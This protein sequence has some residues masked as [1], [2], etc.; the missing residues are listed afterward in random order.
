MTG[1]PFS[2]HLATI[3]LVAASAAL[4]AAGFGF[5][6]SDAAVETIAVEAREPPVPIIPDTLPPTLA[7]DQAFRRPLFQ[8]DRQ[9]T[10]DPS[11]IASSPSRV[12]VSGN[13]MRVKGILINGA[14]AR[15]SVQLADG[16]EPVW[17]SVGDEAGAWTVDTI[18]PE[19]VR[20]RNGDEVAELRLYED[21]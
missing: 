3:G 19:Q 12:T 15:A 8:R 21:R 5:L 16:D 18:T 13:D 11:D 6:A 4:F 1:L 14:R 2:R 9:A 20:L 7:G 10:D 17:L